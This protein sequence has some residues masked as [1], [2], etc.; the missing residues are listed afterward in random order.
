MIFRLP[1]RQDRLVLVDGAKARHRLRQVGRCQD[2]AHALDSRRGCAVDG[3]DPGVAAIE[4]DQLDV[5]GVFE[6]NVRDVSLL[7]GDAPV[8][9]KASLRDADRIG[10]WSAA[11][12]DRT[13]AQ[14]C[15]Y[16]PQRHRFPDRPSLTSASVGYGF[17]RSRQYAAITC[18]GMQK[19][20]WTAPFLT[21]AS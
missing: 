6:L 20:H 3:V 16:A 13:A 15:S 8:A 21:K 2:A 10:H 17:W 4:V 9:A 12:A 5:K 18:P 1:H 7:A 19:P 14:I 11:P